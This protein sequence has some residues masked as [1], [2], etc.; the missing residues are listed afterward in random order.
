MRRALGQLLLLAVTTLT[1]CDYA[2][3]A[4]HGSDAGQ[5]PPTEDETLAFYREL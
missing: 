4:A 5:R 1:G 2:P 3:L